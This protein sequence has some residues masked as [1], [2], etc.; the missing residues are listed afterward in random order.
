M[1]RENVELV[2]RGIRSVDAFWALLAEDVVWDV[3]ANPASGY[4]RRLR[5]AR[6]GY[7]GFAPLLGHLGRLPAGCGGTHR[8]RIERRRRRAGTGAR[9]GQRDSV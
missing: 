1:S 8:R 7:R 6:C 2:R 5:R 3:G 4:P 9:K